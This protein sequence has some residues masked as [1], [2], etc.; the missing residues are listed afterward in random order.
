MSD[1]INIIDRRPDQDKDVLVT[2]GKHMVVACLDGFSYFR[3][4][5]VEVTYDMSDVELDFDGSVTHWMPL[6]EPPSE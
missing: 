3:P 5:N 2:D 4:A 6:P 1:W